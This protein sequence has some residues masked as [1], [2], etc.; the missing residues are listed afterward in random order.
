MQHHSVLGQVVIGY[1]PIIGRQRQVVA[2]RLTVFPARADSTP[3][4]GPLLH[5][6]HEVWPPEAAPDDE[7]LNLSLRTL[8]PSAGTA[9][10][11][12]T[13]RP[14]ASAR[15]LPN[16]A[17]HTSA[18]NSGSKSPS[19]PSA[20]SAPRPARP[21]VAG[22]RAASGVLKLPPVALNVADEG[23]LRTVMQ[24]RPAPHFMIEVPAFMACDPALL[25]T[26]QGLQD[27]GTVLLLKGRPKSPLP[28]EVLACFSHTVVD[29]DDERRA[30]PSAAAPGLRSVTTV[31]SGV[32]TA[33]AAGQAFER[34][35][36][37]VLGW[38]LD[39]PL[40]KASGHCKV[41]TDVQIVLELINGV[42]REEPVGRLEALLKRDPTLAFRLLRYLNSP[43]FGLTVEINSFGHALM[44]LGYQRL[45][46]WLALL[47]AS[48]SKGNNAQALMHAAVRR[49]LMMEQLAF[50]QDNPEVRGEMFIC[51]V[52]S[53]LD[54]LL[55]Q[56][57]S[58]LLGSLP[59]PQRVQQALAGEGGPYGPHLNLVRAVEQEAVFDIRDG[60][61]TLLLG[62]AEVNH[63]VLRAL[64]S[65]RELDG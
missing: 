21:V 19:A 39:D 40:P 15:H 56:P 65:A 5:A 35:A 26:L 23:L 12:I 58:D 33:A 34:G 29:S 42:E 16:T 49:G 28:R 30:L 10:G 45:K 32:R 63:A 24:A 51:G 54:R 31:Q 6:L 47:L 17:P 9:S 43:S 48:S 64:L 18:A 22:L 8:G 14:V 7:P 1:S 62:L 53:L 50:G 3:E 20:P 57:F 55:N 25:G 4:A 36:V 44:L 61:D 46:R 2:T 13:A 52:F 11:S 60:A 27:N 38:P 37:A 41:P 59:V